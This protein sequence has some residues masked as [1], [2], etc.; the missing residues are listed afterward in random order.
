M[1][2][3]RSATFKKEMENKLNAKQSRSDSPLLRIENMFRGS[4]RKHGRSRGFSLIEVLIVVAVAGTLSAIAIPAMISQRRLLRFNGAT[5]EM[6]TQLRSARQLAMS[7]RQAITFQYDDATKSITIIDHN[8]DPLVATSGTAVL[9]DPGYPNTAL[10]AKIVSTVSLLQGGLQSTEISYGIPTTSTGL[11][12]GHPTIPTGPLTD[13]ISM[14]PLSANKINITFQ[15]D[16][17]V[18]SSTGVPLGGITLSQAARA[19]CAIFIFDNKAA[20]GTASA[21]SVLGA[22]GRVKVWRYTNANAYAE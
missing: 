13:G 20:E 21:I 12:S 2:I 19:D 6:A 11:P 1:A 8:N 14:T 3:L 9:A 16:G 5:R 7:E 17:S 10:P 18:A 4:G 22:S 15:A